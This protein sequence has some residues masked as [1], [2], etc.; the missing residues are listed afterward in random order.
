M[1]IIVSP[2]SVELSDNHSYSKGAI[3]NIF[4][5]LLYSLTKYD[6]ELYTLSKGIDISTPFP[7]NLHLYQLTNSRFKNPHYIHMKA[8]IN[9][10]RL[11]KYLLK[12]HDISIVNQ[13]YLPYGVGF[14]PML[15]TIRD[16]PFVIGMCELPHK[17]Y[18]DEIST[19]EKVISKVG[20]NVLHPLF[21]K[22]LDACDVLIA[23]NKPTKELYSK[24]IPR[25]KIRVI[26]YG[27][28]M[29]E[30]K[31]TSLQENNHN[32]LVVSRLIKRRKLN[33]L[34]D[35]M[36]YILDEYPDT[37]L[38]IVGKGPEKI[39][40]IKNHEFMRG[41]FFLGNV[42][43]QKLISLYKNCYVYCSPSKEDGWN[44]PILE[45]MS[46]GRPVICADAPHNSMVNS[47][48]GFKLHYNDSVEYAGTIKRL[49]GDFEMT[50]KLGEEGRREVETNHNWNNIGRKYYEVFRSVM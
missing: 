14:N 9:S 46:T 40:L 24:H 20:R 41:V 6:I 26:P 28:D 47:K 7:T 13:M 18:N 39:N 1:K 38:H 36:P 22:T 10:I 11:S 21:L 45:A 27:V 35:A 2:A 33:I 43:E 5:N 8:L 23:V 44:Q 19:T 4:Y 37:K 32:I 34:I 17:R 49:F 16:Y 42:N 3:S 50:K 12:E 15:K 31:F 29:N 48:S 30:F 25:R